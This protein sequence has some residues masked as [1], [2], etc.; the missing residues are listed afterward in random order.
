MREFT[1]TPTVKRRLE[2]RNIKLICASSNCLFNKSNDDDKFLVDAKHKEKNAISLKAYTVCTSCG[3]KTPYQNSVYH[4][5][6]KALNSKKRHK[7][8]EDKQ[9]ILCE[10]CKSHAKIFWIQQVISK[11]LKNSHK[12]YHKECYLNLFY[13]SSD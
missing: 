9:D 3:H 5:I 11:H 10:N 4:N 2:G 1:L 12:L 6:N 8:Q 13:D 7:T